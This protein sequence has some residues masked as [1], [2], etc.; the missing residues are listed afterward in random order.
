[1]TILTEGRRDAQYLVSEA[2]GDRSRA[3]VIVTVPDA[4]L[5]AGMILGKI[6]STGKFV[7]HDAAAA[8]GS[9]VEAGIL[10]ANLTNGTGAAVD[11]TATITARDA[12]VRGSD[13][14]YEVGV[15][16]AQKIASNAALAALGIIVR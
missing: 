1:M 4:G 11:A 15:D 10:Y 5:E 13:L 14:T 12:E 8:D 2:N 3:E 7:R 6:T 9:Q 16:A